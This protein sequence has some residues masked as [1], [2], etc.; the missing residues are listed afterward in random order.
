MENWN[1]A[2]KTPWR[3]LRSFCQ[4]QDSSPNPG[5]KKSHRSLGKHREFLCFH[6][7]SLVN[8]WF[9]ASLWQQEVW[10]ERKIGIYLILIHLDWL[11]LDDPGDW[12]SEGGSGQGAGIGPVVRAGGDQTG[13]IK[14]IKLDHSILNSRKN[15]CE[16]G[17]W[18][19]KK[20][21]KSWK[22]SWGYKKCVICVWGCWEY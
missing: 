8:N 3:G 11:F 18:R 1:K 13:G 20:L 7:D 21:Q 9:W 17:V 22:R 15:I 5:L 2:G 12:L 4:R 19:K 14:V 16:D 6:R 10:S